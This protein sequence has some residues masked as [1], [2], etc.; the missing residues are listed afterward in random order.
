VLGSIFALR[1]GVVLGPLVALVLWRGVP[2]RTLALSAGAIL[3]VA[4]PALYILFPPR[5]QGGWSTDYAKELLGAHWVAAA[6]L[7]LLLV[8]VWQVMRAA[9]GPT[10]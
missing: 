4:V 5:D 2:A 1:S 7:T 10:A 9:R 8:A 3:A 6:A